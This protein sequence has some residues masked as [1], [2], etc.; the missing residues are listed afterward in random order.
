MEY[1]IVG[2]KLGH[3]YS[4]KIH[5]QLGV[6]YE[7]KEV[8]ESQLVDLLS[9]REF[10]GINVTIPYKQTVIPYLDVVDSR[11]L[12]I[13]A[14]NSIV[15]REGKLYGYNTDYDGLKYMIERS[16]VDISGMH[17][18]ILGSGGTSKTAEC[19]ASDMGA[20]SVIKVSRSGEINYNNINL[21]NEINVIINTSPYGM[22]PD[23]QAVPL[24]NI[25]DYPDSRL[26]IDVIYNPIKTSLICDAECSGIP[27]SGGLTML[28]AQAVS[29]AKIFGYGEGA[30]IERLTCSL[31]NSERNIILI[32]MPS[33]GKSYVGAQVAKELDKDFYDSDKVFYTEYGITPSEM[34][35]TSGEPKFRELETAVIKKLC[36]MRGIVI[37]TGGGAI[38]A[39]ENRYYMRSNGIILHVV[40]NLD[41]LCIGGD[42]PLSSNVQAI[43]QMYN[44]RIPIYR[45]LADYSLDN[46]FDYGNK[47]IIDF[48]RWYN[49]NIGN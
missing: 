30:D 39:N 44:A 3:S 21:H 2:A 42:R 9:S 5:V 13:G 46:D 14:V 35:I 26:V 29:A 40:R 23:I 19:L 24:I 7:L 38:L 49:E 20:Q 28:V 25:K 8:D 10:K 17:V 6:N 34:I 1:G 37:S 4:A 41:K 12:R 32:G 11:A 15:N 48:M 36:N 22:Y 43:K 31:I 18:A 27:N 47:G 16:G 45:E 33:S